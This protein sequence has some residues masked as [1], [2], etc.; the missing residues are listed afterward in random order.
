MD[1]QRWAAIESLYRTALAKDPS[2]RSPY[3]AIACAEDLTLRGEVESLLAYADA[4]L[5]DPAQLSVLARTAPTITAAPQPPKFSGGE[6][7]GERFRIVRFIGRGGMGEVYEAEDLVLRESVALKTIRPELVDSG[8]MLTRFRR[9]VNAAKSI[10]HP[11]VCRVHDLHQHRMQTRDQDTVT[12]LTMELLCGEALDARLVRAGAMD[13]PE[14]RLVAEQLVSALTAAH[15]AGVI[16]CDFKTGNI[17]LTSAPGG[18]VR[19]VVT[20]FGLAHIAGT[21]ESCSITQTGSIA[22]TPAYMAPEQLRGER[23]TAAVDIYALGVVLCELVAGV[24]PA[25][26]GV[27]EDLAV[28]NLPAEWKIAVR[29]CLKREPGDRFTDASEVWKAIAGGRADTAPRRRSRSRTFFPIAGLT[30]VALPAALLAIGILTHRRAPPIPAEKKIAVLLFTNIGR[31]QS[32]QPLA[33]GLI[34]VIS[35]ALTRLEEFNGALVVI[36]AG[37]AARITSARDAGR[38]LNAN[39]ALTG[40]IE[41][42]SG[43]QVRVLLNLVDTHTLTQLRS[44]V[45]QGNLPDLF[46]IQD[47][48]VNEVARLLELELRPANAQAALIGNTAVAQAYPFYVRGLG[49][50]RSYDRDRNIDKAIESF[51]HALNADPRYVLSYAGLAQA[52]WMKYDTLKDAQFLDKAFETC[53][54]ALALNDRLAPV[55]ITMGT[56]EAGKGKYE[57]AEVEFATALRIDPRSADAYREL[58]RTYE[59]RGKR[60]QAEATYKKA[61]ELRGDDWWSVKQ[62]GLFYFNRGPYSEAEPWF[63]QVIRLTP[64]SPGAYNN[65]GALY[66]KMGRSADALDQ[67]RKSLSVEPTANAWSNIGSYYYF[68]GDYRNAAAQFAKA[69]ELTPGDSRNWGNLADAYRWTPQLASKA[70]DAYRRALELIHG[71]IGINPRDARLHSKAA[72]WWAALGERDQAA[73]EIARAIEIAPVDAFVQYRAALVYEQAGQ[74]D[75]ALRAVKSALDAGYSLLEIQKAPPLESLRAD[76]RFSRLLR[77]GTRANSN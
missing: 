7:L 40:S 47:D 23:V 38:V 37:E 16:H 28:E 59:A 18:R 31:D 3:L 58:G 57:R 72:M 8:I 48:A 53:A 1:P 34:Q 51:A 2:E 29:R 68:E 14:A 69:V 32:I 11:N 45:L 52:Y 50:L 76:S 43:D 49:Y 4:E 5:P 56:I 39:L 33:D 54:Q 6:L 74:R 65:L 22:G 66:L 9:E 67:F 13:L 25:A 17:I 10:S 36:P 63:R 55:H 44:G 26:G 41:R 27:S 71:E 64:D 75:R 35:N 30:A 61:L 24:R 60:L 77:S 73:A 20:D 12:F 46:G 21:A 42:S 70:P 15:N 19:T 62:L